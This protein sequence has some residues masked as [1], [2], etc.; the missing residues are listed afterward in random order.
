M[1]EEIIGIKAGSSI[2]QGKDCYER[3]ADLLIPLLKPTRQIY[4]VVSAEKGATDATIDEIAGEER[5]ILNAA[6]Q[7][8]PS[9][10]SER[11]NNS[12]IAARLVAPENVSVRRLR[13]AIW[14]RGFDSLGLQHGSRDIPYP[15][16]GL[17]NH[18]YLYAEPDLE[19][20][21]QQ[22]SYG[23]KLI[24]VPGFGVRTPSGEIMCTGRGS[25]DLTL[26]QLGALYGMDEIIFWKD[27]G[28]FWIDA[29]RPETGVYS[30]MT[31]DLARERGTEKVLDR[32][33]Y[34]IYDGRVR[35]TGAGKLDGGT[36]ILPKERS[37]GLYRTRELVA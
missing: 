22:R 27:S 15:L 24:I 36:L 10:A 26:A 5:E 13:N 11:W 19:A 29:S 7:G 35:I 33:V 21:K 23:N 3:V 20:S 14:G 8:R 25:S 37:E 17:E 4:F 1:V 30:T 2:F 34:N 32:R 9:E 6:L 28:G 31:R 16:I 12:T 18:N